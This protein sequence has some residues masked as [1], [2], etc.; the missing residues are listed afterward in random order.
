MSRNITVYQRHRLIDR[1]R[2]TTACTACWA[3]G[4]ND[5]K[6]CMV[7]K[8][9]VLGQLEQPRQDTNVLYWHDEPN[10]PTKG[11]TPI[12]CTP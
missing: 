7:R 3:M 11:R 1:R 12:I 10:N 4:T 5:V 9:V 2:G 8:Y 6:Y